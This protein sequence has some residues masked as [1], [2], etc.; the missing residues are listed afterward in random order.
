VE[1]YWIAQ[2]RDLGGIKRKVSLGPVK[3][4]TKREAEERLDKILE[5]INSRLDEPSPEM[6]FGSFVRQVYL[7][8]YSRKW[9]GSTTK[10]NTDRVEHHL[11]S[12]FD[13]RPLGSFSRGRDELQDFLDRKSKA[14]LSYSVTAHLRWDLRQ[15]FRMAVSEQYLERNPAE[16]LFIPRE[17]PRAETR[18][19]TLDEVRQFFAVLDLRERVIGGLAVLAGMRPG[20]IFAL[21]RSRAE[22][23]YANIQQRV[24]RGEIDTPK[25]FKS[26]RLAALGGGLLVWI[27]QWMEMLPTENRMVGCFHRSG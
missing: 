11:L 1:G 27:R 24:Y 6:K 16:L 17:A 9:K 15:I 26:R 14:G 25:T 23:E 13:R 21:T 10:T 5:P 2:Y 4:T 19:M 3:A 7:P 8:F 18:R 22:S 12:E 20:E